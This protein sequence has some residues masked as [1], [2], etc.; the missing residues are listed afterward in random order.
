MEQEIELI[1]IV[2]KG[3]NRKRNYQCGYE[4]CSFELESGEKIWCGFFIPHIRAGFNVLIIGEWHET[5]EYFCAREVR[6]II[7]KPKFRQLEL[8]KFMELKNA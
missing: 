6:Q 1:G 4:N 2:K 7:D 5:K 3:I 8:K